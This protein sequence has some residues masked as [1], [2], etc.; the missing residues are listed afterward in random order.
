MNLSK[1][2]RWRIASVA[3]WVAIAL[4]AFACGVTNAGAHS[5]ATESWRP[6]VTEAC[7]SAGCDPEQ[8]LAIIDCESNGLENPVPH[9]NPY[10]GYDRGLLMINDA[11]WGDV[12]YAG[13][14]TQIWWAASLL[15]QPG[16]WYHWTCAGGVT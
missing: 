10:G 13:G 6:T 8:M 1:Q 12:A 4:I 16:G 15:A 3:L 11:T 9:A 2:G 7:L 14:V 5:A